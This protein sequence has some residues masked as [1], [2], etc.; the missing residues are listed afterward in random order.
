MFSNFSWYKQF[1]HILIHEDISPFEHKKVHDPTLKLRAI[2]PTTTMNP[3]LAMVG[4]SRVESVPQSAS[5]GK[6]K[7][8][9]VIPVKEATEIP[10]D[11][12]RPQENLS[13]QTAHG[14]TTLSDGEKLAIFDS[15]ARKEVSGSGWT[16]PEI[17]TKYSVH[18]K[19]EPRSDLNSQDG[20]PERLKIIDHNEFL[21]R[22]QEVAST[23][24][25]L[26]AKEHEV[27]CWERT[28]EGLALFFFPESRKMERHKMS[29]SL[30]FWHKME[31]EDEGSICNEPINSVDYVVVNMRQFV[32][33]NFE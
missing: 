7:V 32:S 8:G 9:Y 19:L 22:V 21:H 3:G 10:L 20:S 11:V 28:K 1:D 2:G 18:G 24:E 12:L 4:T 17:K 6:T 33:K 23:L 15:L 30:L 29:K 14:E 16:S 13:M 26:T 5:R 25:T 27:S 31:A